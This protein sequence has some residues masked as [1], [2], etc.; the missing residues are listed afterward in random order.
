MS[1]PFGKRDHGEDRGTRGQQG[2]HILLEKP[3]P[4]L[5][6]PWACDPFKSNGM[7][8]EV[9]SLDFDSVHWLEG[10]DYV[11][12]CAQ[13]GDFKCKE[14]KKNYPDFFDNALASVRLILSDHSRLTT[15]HYC[16]CLDEMLHF[17]KNRSRQLLKA[18]PRVVPSFLTHVIPNSLKSPTC[19]WMKLP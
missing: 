19:L 16:Y 14:L 12:V 9:N 3:W 7:L 10:S 6:S 11:Q 1:K 13:A 17:H 8:A 4:G 15:I 5:P 2:K 18:E